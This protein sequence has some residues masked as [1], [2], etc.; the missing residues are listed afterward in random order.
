MLLG[1]F[2][3]RIV[4][5]KVFYQERAFA[6]G[7]TQAAQDFEGSLGD[8]LEGDS[9]GKFQGDVKRSVDYRMVRYAWFGLALSIGGALYEG[10][11][12]LLDTG[13]FFFQYE[14]I[15]LYLS[16]MPFML[17][18]F[19]ESGWLESYRDF[20]SYSPVPHQIFLA[21]AMYADNLL[22]TSHLKMKAPGWDFEGHEIF[23]VLTRFAYIV[24]LATAACFAAGL[25]RAGNMLYVVAPGCGLLM[26]GVW[27]LCHVLVLSVYDVTDKTSVVQEVA[28]PLYIIACF[29]VTMVYLS[30]MRRWYLQSQI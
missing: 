21:L 19:V 4:W 30:Y 22:W 10:F 26:N 29:V 6:H 18:M 2:Y 20:T 8:T 27:L 28:Y 7:Y 5:F 23:A 12:G 1:I 24:H 11:G 14:H 17:C 25:R 9:N 16:Y 13:N 3:T 15:V